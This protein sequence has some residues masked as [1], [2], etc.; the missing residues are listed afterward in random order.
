MKQRQVAARLRFEIFCFTV[1]DKGIKKRVRPSYFW[2]LEHVKSEFDEPVVRIG[3][4]IT[5]TKVK[6]Q[7]TY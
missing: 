2:I 1:M 7:L 4:P 6:Y 3:S 5:E